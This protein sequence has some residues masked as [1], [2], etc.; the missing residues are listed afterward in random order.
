VDPVEIPDGQDGAW[1]RFFNFFN[2]F[3]Q[4]HDCMP[5]EVKAA[6]NFGLTE[7]VKNF[8]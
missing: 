4:Y 1:E 5:K 3:N 7:N 8:S 2:I 6:L